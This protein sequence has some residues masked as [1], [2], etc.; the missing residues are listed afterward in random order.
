M[1]I[2]LHIIKN[3]M[4]KESKNELAVPFIQNDTLMT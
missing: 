3:N 2:I 4:L 1:G